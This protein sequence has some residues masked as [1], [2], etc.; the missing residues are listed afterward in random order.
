MPSV[1]YT[2]LAVPAAG[3]A[4]V[5]VVGTRGTA[6]PPVQSLDVLAERMN[7]NTSSSLAAFVEAC[8]LGLASGIARQ[9]VPG[10]DY[11][12]GLAPAALLK[13][14]AIHASRYTIS[15]ALRDAV[16]HGHIW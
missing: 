3:S 16:P 2:S 7:L 11:S 10:K 8:P 13:A 5:F 12:R 4:A 9:L 14:P 1:L 15:V 6:F